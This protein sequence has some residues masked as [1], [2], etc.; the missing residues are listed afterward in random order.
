VCNEKVVLIDAMKTYRDV[1]ARGQ[2]HVPFNLT[3]AKRPR[4]NLNMRLGGPQSGFD[5][6]EKK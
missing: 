5:I 3:P 1:E 2:P 6:L 4:C